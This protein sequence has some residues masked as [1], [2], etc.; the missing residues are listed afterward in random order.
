[1]HLEDTCP[2]PISSLPHACVSESIERDLSD[3]PARDK[4]S[5]DFPT[6]FC[7]S[8]T[9]LSAP[10][11]WLWLE[12]DWA[13]ADWLKDSSRGTAVSVI[14]NVAGSSKPGIQSQSSDMASSLRS[15]CLTGSGVLPRR[16]GAAVVRNILYWNEI[17]KKKSEHWLA[18]VKCWPNGAAGHTSYFGE[19]YHRIM[20]VGWGG[21]GWGFCRGRCEEPGWD[22][23]KREWGIL[24][25]RQ[26]FWRRDEGGSKVGKKQEGEK[27]EWRE[28]EVENV[29]INNNKQPVC[30]DPDSIHAHTYY[31]WS[32][33]TFVF[34]SFFLL[35]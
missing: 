20:G 7:P 21:G 33:M 27:D 4:A 1:M 29:W 25:K 6:P 31:R 3:C 17:Q 12:D 9:I 15:W 32:M 22:R 13:A 28:E 18:G 2:S 30:S 34:V 5:D 14:G 16:R 35:K 24:M 26:L 23:Q 19:C 8:R 11:P 10:L